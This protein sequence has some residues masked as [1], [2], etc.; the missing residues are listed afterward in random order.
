MLEIRNTVQI[1]NVFSKALHWD[2]EPSFSFSNVTRTIEF[3]FLSFFFFPG[4]GTKTE[5]RSRL[6]GRSTVDH[7]GQLTLLE[8]QQSL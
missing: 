2:D 7:V 3:F 4:E 6:L 8:V 1:W 5:S